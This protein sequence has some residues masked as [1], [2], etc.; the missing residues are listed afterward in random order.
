VKAPLLHGGLADHQAGGLAFDVFFP[1]AESLLG[2]SFSVVLDSG[3]FWQGVL[4]RG[5]AL[6]DRS[7]V[8]YR[9]VRCICG[10]VSERRLRSRERLI[11]QP[12]SRTELAISMARPGVILTLAEPHLD[13]DTTQPLEDCVE[14]VLEY[15]RS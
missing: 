13:V 11:S 15:L 12:S 6:A 7:S 9:L 8:D 3:A 5:R 1:L 4:D 14:R 2:Q 10:D